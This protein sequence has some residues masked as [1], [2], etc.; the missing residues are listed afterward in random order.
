MLGKVTS[1]EKG[2]LVTTCCIIGASGIALPPVII[3]P[4]KNYKD[5]MLKGA[6]P[7]SLGLAAP[8]GWMNSE[9]FVAVIRHF[10][11][12][13]NSSPENPS[14]LIFDNHES[15]LSLEALN[16]AKSFG[17]TV[18]TLHPHTSAKL[19]PLDVGVFGPF[20]TFF[21]GAIDSW[22][23]RNPG[24]PITIYDLAECIGTAYNRAMTPMNIINSFKSCGIFP[25]DRNIFTDIDFLP[26]EV[27]NRP[28]AE[29]LHTTEKITDV[30][31]AG[32][33]NLE[34]N[35]EVSL[36]DNEARHLSVNDVLQDI[37]AASTGQNKFIF[38]EEF[39]P[40]LRA[41]PRNNTR[42]PRKTKKSIIATDTPE[43]TLIKDEKS[44]VN[45]K[46]SLKKRKNVIRKVLQDESEIESNES[47]S[48]HSSSGGNWCES[49]DDEV[50]VPFLL[51]PD[52]FEPLGRRPNEGE[53]VLVEFATKKTLVFYVGKV[54]EGNVNTEEYYINFLRIK[55]RDVEQ[56]IEPQIKDAA[57]VKEQDI[58]YILP[59][60]EENGGTMRQQ[61]FFKFNMSFKALKMR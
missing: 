2:T 59:K 46:K 5:H 8:S 9:L 53:Y 34:A 36:L 24:K 45:R 28:F 35:S 7:G 19:Q 60:P 12:N 13:S 31:G 15:H 21:N 18:L 4:R 26:S 48:S 1:G 38:P 58:K 41:G 44:F 40:P 42:K 11:K 23:L 56:F 14:L 17:V 25:F 43:M 20:K 33:S 49:E 37:T 47:F 27:T 29:D 61:S 57:Y 16:L 3:F 10:I 55:S 6:P 39:R 51:T 22:L 32:P 52:S 54:L 50:D 30:T